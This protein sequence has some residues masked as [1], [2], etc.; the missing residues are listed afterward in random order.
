MTDFNKYNTTLTNEQKAMMAQAKQA[1]IYGKDVK[2][3]YDYPEVVKGTYLVQITSM[4]LREEKNRL[5]FYLNFKLL[6]GM[7]DKTIEFMSSWPGTGKP[8]IP[9]NR[10]ITHTKND[11]SCLGSVLGWLNR[12]KETDRINFDGDYGKLASTIDEIFAEVKDNYAYKI[13]YEPE[14]FY[15]FMVLEIFKKSDDTEEAPE[16]QAESESP[17]A[18]MP[19]DAET[20][21]P[22]DDT[23]KM[24]TPRMVQM[25]SSYPGEASEEDDDDGF[26]PVDEEEDDLPF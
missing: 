21:E 2:P 3:K 1:V 10:P 6:E 22:N 19:E 14:E 5:K 20:P 7:D 18:P 26:V 17:E 9:F 23:P 15:R 13:S 4:E 12:F 8:T 11:S 16:S 25:P 24:V